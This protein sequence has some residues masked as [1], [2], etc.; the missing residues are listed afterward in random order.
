MGTK[1]LFAMQMGRMEQKQSVGAELF[2]VSPE[3]IS[4]FLGRAVP[5]T[6]PWRIS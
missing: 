2:G 4:K 1:I 3:I 5:V 6:C